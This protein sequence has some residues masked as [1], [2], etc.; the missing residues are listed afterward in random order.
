V[1][2]AFLVAV[3]VVVVVVVIV[4]AVVVIII[5]A[6]KKVYQKSRLRVILRASRCKALLQDTQLLGTH[7]AQ[8][9]NVENDDDSNYDQVHDDKLN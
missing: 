3:I 8:D 7:I 4:V 9:A 1:V 2:I 6:P 5:V